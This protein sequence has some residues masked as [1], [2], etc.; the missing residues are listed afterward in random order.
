VIEHLGLH[1]VGV[2]HRTAG[3]EVRERFALTPDDLALLLRQHAA[4]GRS[5]LF[6]STCNRSE[7]Y[8]SGAHDLQGWFTD[9]AHARGVRDTSAIARWDGLAAT[10]HL[11]DVAAGLDSQVL[12]ETE[13]L[14]Q[15]R[16]AYDVARAAGATTWEMDIAFSSA[17]AAGRRVRHETMLGRHPAS[18][19]SAAVD[20]V[21]EQIGGL[22][23]RTVVVLGAGEA[24]EGVLG[25]LSGQ[26]VAS[27]T[28]CNR[29]PERA[30]PLADV[31]QADVAPWSALPAC[32]ATADAVFVA[33]AAKQPVV[34]APQLG[35]ARDGAANRPLV[36]VDLSVPRNVDPAVRDLAQVTLVDLD[37]L[38]RLRCPVTDG[39][40]PALTEARRIL[41]D[42]IVRLDARLR[43]RA[44][45]PQLAD[46]HRFGNE[47]VERETA[48]ALAQLHGLSDDQRQVVREMAD[49]LVRR[50]LYP[51]SR[52]VRTVDL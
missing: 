41:E 24:A 18:V 23:G 39:A 6:L 1:V 38:Q 14:G 33:T 15:V 51:M 42:E 28:L 26:Q 48:W 31:W 34:T 10:R 44:A 50:V 47:L 43:A 11:F 2:N 36:V 4:A 49:R 46:L 8:W 40:A 30:K 52:A 19:S 25:A 3:V 35:A 13:I 29:R 22:K 21:A 27:V 16:R 20:L 7:L 9:F 12:G 37:D 32:L 5:A 17:L 45:S